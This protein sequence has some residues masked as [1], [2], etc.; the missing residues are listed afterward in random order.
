MSLLSISGL[1]YIE[2]A[3]LYLPLYRRAATTAAHDVKYRRRHIHAALF[4]LGL[5]VTFQLN[6]ASD[7]R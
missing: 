2:E 1:L 7:A 6:C 3:T 4:L 5:Y